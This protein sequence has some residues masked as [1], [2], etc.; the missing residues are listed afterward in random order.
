MSTI[1]TVRRSVDRHRGNTELEIE[2]EKI[3]NR[4]NKTHES[5][6]RM[7]DRHYT[8]PVDETSGTVELA[9]A[10]GITLK[11]YPGRRF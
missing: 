2:H 7:T 6:I 10:G 9:S 1:P 5:V 11:E 3:L 8:E 4:M